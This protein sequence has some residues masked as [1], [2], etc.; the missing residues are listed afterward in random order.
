MKL[1]GP[2]IQLLCILCFIVCAGRGGEYSP[3]FTCII[4]I[5]LYHVFWKGDN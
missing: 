4:L 3:Y 2:V 5:L 1:M